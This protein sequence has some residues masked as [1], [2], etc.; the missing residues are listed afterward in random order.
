MEI[1]SYRASPI[2]V[3]FDKKKSL[4]QNEFNIPKKWFKSKTSLQVED[5]NIVKRNELEREREKRQQKFRFL[6][7]PTYNPE[8]S[9]EFFDLNPVPIRHKIMKIKVICE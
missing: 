7:N 8:Y 9:Y 3:S 4:E 5:P 6:P 2:F 1:S